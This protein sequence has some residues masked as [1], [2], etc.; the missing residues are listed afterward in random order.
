MKKQSTSET[1][2]VMREMRTMEFR[3]EEFE[4]C[5]HFHKDEKRQYQYTTTELDEINYTQ[6]LNKYRAKHNLP[7]PE[8]IK[9]IREKYQLPAAKMSEI[10]GLGANSY[11][12]Y[13]A[14]EVPS[15][16]IGKLIQMSADPLKFKELVNLCD[17]IDGDAKNKI[18]AR[19]NHHSAK[20]DEGFKWINIDD[21]FADHI[22]PSQLTGYRKPSLERFAHM[23]IRFA[24]HLEPWKTQLNK[25]LFYAD[26][27]HYK[28]HAFSITGCR[29]AA[30]QMGPVPKR[31]ETVFEDLSTKDYFDVMY[32]EFPDGN[33]GEQFKSRSD[34]PFDSTLF[35]EQELE[36]IDDVIKM[37]G[38]LKRTELVET[39]HKERGW[40]ANHETKGLINYDYAFD[41]K[42]L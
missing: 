31:F 42:A 10:L 37:L 9:A 13:E 39:S 4:I 19:I 38:K 2:A 30:I 18:V 26:F 11:R 7:F 5:F 15:T 27:L 25:L 36:T 3:K 29:Y 17:S 40:I 6:L 35:S 1:P 23:I 20:D 22:R 8:E 28:R 34:H 32:T 41:L 12:Q 14:G 33:I 21:Y 24:D 16:S